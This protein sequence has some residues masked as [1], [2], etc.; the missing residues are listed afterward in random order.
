[1][2]DATFKVVIK[3]VLINPEIKVAIKKISVNG[4]INQGL[5]S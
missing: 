4:K 3:K 5:Q 2:L 1:M